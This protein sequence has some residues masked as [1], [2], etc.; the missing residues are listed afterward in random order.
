MYKK[1][2]DISFEITAASELRNPIQFFKLAITDFTSS[3]QYSKRILIENLTEKYRYSSIGI[4]WTLIP[5]VVITFYFMF[6]AKPPTTIHSNTINATVSSGAFITYGMII[7]QVFFG[8]FRDGLSLLLSKIHSFTRQRLKIEA[9]ILAYIGEMILTSWMKVP[10]LLIISWFLDIPFQPTCFL[11]FILLPIVVF[12]AAGLGLLFSIWNILSSDVEGMLS[13]VPFVILGFTPIFVQ[14]QTGSIMYYIHQINP[15]SHLL[16]A[17]RDAAF[18]N[19][20]L[21]DPMFIYACGLSVFILFFSWFFI[22][23]SLPHVIER[24]LG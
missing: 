20:T 1:N 10:I 7:F 18:G 23:I 6:L 5:T 2:T 12:L 15:L 9:F 13:F 8:A 24:H 14:Y 4:F 19:L 16:N 22:R 3:I 11:I 21:S 17:I